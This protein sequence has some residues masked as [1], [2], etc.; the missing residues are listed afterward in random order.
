M[1]FFI[2]LMAE[3][4]VP[5]G[6][7][8]DMRSA[9]YCRRILWLVCGYSDRFVSGDVQE[10]PQG[11]RHYWRH[12]SVQT[13]E[14]VQEFRCE[15]IS[16]SVHNIISVR[17]LDLHIPHLSRSTGV[18]HDHLLAA[19]SSKSIGSLTL[20]EIMRLRNNTDGGENSEDEWEL[21]LEGYRNWS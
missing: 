5:L 8:F 9:G 6:R 16:Q 14:K 19:S 3:S 1:S 20:L 12:A 4:L 11:R 18:N 13:Q 21:H 7:A 15:K 17:I 10:H 2:V